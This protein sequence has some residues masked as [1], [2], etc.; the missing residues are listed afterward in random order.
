MSVPESTAVPGPDESGDAFSITIGP[1]HFG[2]AR[3]IATATAFAVGLITTI[4]VAVVA[5]L[6]G[7]IG[8]VYVLTAFAAWV[9]A[10]R[11]SWRI[12]PDRIEARRWFRWHTVERAD[13]SAI[14]AARDEMGIRAVA[15][16]AGGTPLEIDVDDV[17][18]EPLLADALARFVD[19]CHDDG[20][21]IDPLVTTLVRR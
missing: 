18:V 10:F 9:Q 3:D 5:G 2:G 13:V 16:A 17:R 6:P 1:R 15:L 19:D 20:A 11:R 12:S 14:E 4:L 7:V 21:T 8:T